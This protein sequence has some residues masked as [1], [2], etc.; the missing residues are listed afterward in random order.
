MIYNETLR[1]LKVLLL[2]REHAGR[3]FP[4]KKVQTTRY[5]IP[6]DSD[7]NTHRQVNLQLYVT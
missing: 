4:Q 5:H 2:N 3:R 1:S 6:E 7:L